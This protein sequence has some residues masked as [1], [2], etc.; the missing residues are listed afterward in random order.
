MSN[1][2][3]SHPAR[4]TRMSLGSVFSDHRID[5]VLML[6]P[7]LLI[8]AAFVLAPIL[9][10]FLLSL[11]NWDGISPNRSWAGLDNYSFILRSGRF[12]H[13][14]L[15]NVIWA[16]LSIIPMTLGLILAV[17]LY[18]GRVRGSVFFRVCFLLPFT[19]S[20]V[21]VAI[22]WAWIY[23]P[24]WGTVNVILRSVGLDELARS[25]LSNPNTA[26]IAMNMVGSWTWFGF[27]MVIFLA[28][29]QTISSEIYDAARVDGA[30]PLQTF[31]H[32]TIPMLRS[33][34][35][36][37]AIVT[38]IFSFKVF[39]LVFVM[40]KGGPFQSSEVLGLLIYLQGFSL[41]KIGQAS[42]TAVILTVLVFLISFAVYRR[43]RDAT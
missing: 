14:F 35:R 9:Q 11:Q 18:Q 5:G 8:Y 21:I 4:E 27:C 10:T 1:P 12:W 25:W 26:L 38:L 7:G 24:E 41:Y 28:G 23:Q 40:T 31:C 43:S 33:H 34:I 37:L 20:Q 17:V 2:V 6:L 42:A 32:I 39:D 16:A 3:L 29:L 30:T 22:V 15:N 19:L 13:A 36:M